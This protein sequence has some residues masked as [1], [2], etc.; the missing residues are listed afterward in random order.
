MKF[1]DLISMKR[2]YKR[3][4]VNIKNAIFIDLTIILIITIFLTIGLI[5]RYACNTMF[6]CRIDMFV[7]IIHTMINVK[8]K[9]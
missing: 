7:V 5:C 3:I 6:I 2:P 9:V 1:N 4:N 8:K